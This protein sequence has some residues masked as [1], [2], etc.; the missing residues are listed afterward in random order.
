LSLRKIA[1]AELVCEFIRRLRGREVANGGYEGASMEVVVEALNKVMN[2]EEITSTF[3][4]LIDSQ[5]I[6]VTGRIL[7]NLPSKK[8]PKDKWFVEGVV[9][10]LH[11]DIKLKKDIFYF[12]P[13]GSILQEVR[14]DGR[15]V[16]PSIESH[17]ISL[18]L[19]MCYVSEDGLPNSVQKLAK[20]PLPKPV[21][22]EYR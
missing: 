22:P 20:H 18:Y 10:K 19:Q 1:D 14:R 17:F 12:S 8:L 13:A 5:T 7:E 9:E 2:I 21:L 3:Q 6:V 4:E 16:R 11:P 15:R